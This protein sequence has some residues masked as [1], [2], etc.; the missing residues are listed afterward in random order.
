MSENSSLFSEMICGDFI[1]VSHLLDCIYKCGH[2]HTEMVNTIARDMVKSGSLQTDQLQATGAQ[3]AMK[4]FRAIFFSRVMDDQLLDQ[5]KKIFVDFVKQN[6]NYFSG[7]AFL[8]I[9]E[10]SRTAGL[11]EFSESY[12]KPKLDTSYQLTDLTLKNQ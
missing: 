10:I 3:K 4:Y 5:H 12:L 2:F 6:E 7:K 8:T 9:L 1:Y 11:K